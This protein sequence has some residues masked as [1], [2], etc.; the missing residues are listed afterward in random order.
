MLHDLVLLRSPLLFSERAQTKASL[1]Q[2]DTDQ[3]LG[4]DVD[5]GTDRMDSDLIR[6]IRWF[7]ERA[8]LEAHSQQR[9]T[10]G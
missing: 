3:N 1:A 6:N 10:D 8:L 9:L 5:G 2:Q 7:K 4:M